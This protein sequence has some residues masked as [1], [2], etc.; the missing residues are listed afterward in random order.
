MGM[1]DKGIQALIAKVLSEETVQEINGKIE[2]VTLEEAIIRATARRALDERNRLAMEAT[3]F[4][5]EY[6]YGKPIQPVAAVIGRFRGEYDGF[7]EEELKEIEE[8]LLRGAKGGHIEAAPKDPGRFIEA[9]RRD[10]IVQAVVESRGE[11]I[12][13]RNK[14]ANRAAQEVRKK[15]S[16]EIESNPEGTDELTEYD[17]KLIVDQWF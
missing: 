9:G 15:V 8:K 16:P 14:R 3:R 12:F 2:N 5:T 11:D 1:R 7:S 13:E 17:R 4:L 6:Q 10:Q